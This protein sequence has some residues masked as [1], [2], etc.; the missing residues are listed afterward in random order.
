MRKTYV[1]LDKDLYGGL[2]STGKVVLDAKVFELIPDTETCEGWDAGR[3]DGLLDKV[4]KEW[5][6]YGCLVSQ[7]P[8]VLRER[9][10]L[11][12]DAAIKNA[13]ASGWSGEV[14]IGDDK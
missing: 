10:Q 4:N 8:P 2:T 13:G 9:H 7:L 3:M 12:Y 11:I 5:D 6:K 1:G 14:E